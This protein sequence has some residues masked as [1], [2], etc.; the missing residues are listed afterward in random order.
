MTRMRP[1]LLFSFIVIFLDG[2][3]DPFYVPTVE[4][5]MVI[6]VEGM[7]TDQPGPYNVDL[8]YSNNINE[9]LSFVNKVR[10]ASVVLFDDQG[11]SEVL[12]EVAPGNY[13]T[14]AN[15]IKGIVGN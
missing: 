7:I 15:G 6:V 10:Q 9:A 1:L 2:C 13:Q 8:S 3:I 4:N 12:R 14:S 11:N 5:E